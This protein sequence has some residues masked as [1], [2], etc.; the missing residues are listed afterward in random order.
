LKICYG[1]QMSNFA[2]LSSQLD[3]LRNIYRQIFITII[4]NTPGNNLPRYRYMVI[5][6][7]INNY[8]QA[9]K[10][11][12]ESACKYPQR[13]ELQHPNYSSLD[14]ELIRSRLLAQKEC[15]LLL[16]P[17]DLHRK[18]LDFTLKKTQ[19]YQETQSSISEM[20]KQNPSLVISYDFWQPAIQAEIDRTT[21]VSDSIIHT[22][23][24]ML[25]EST[26]KN[27]REL[28][29]VCYDLYT[30]FKQENRKESKLFLDMTSPIPGDT[31][32][33][34]LF[35][36]VGMFFDRCD[37]IANETKFGCQRNSF[38]GLL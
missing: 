3:V 16:S 13:E 21:G 36:N 25:V 37:L 33:S 30:E 4:E 10:D 20:L 24:L 15:I 7:D 17:I 19:E 28:A 35:A 6:E 27:N 26:L 12:R 2:A 34:R 32:L 38:E 5:K 31:E 8:N 14:P 29:L 11:R 1:I 23:Q 18:Q 9:I 22:L